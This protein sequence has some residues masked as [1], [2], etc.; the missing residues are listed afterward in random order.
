MY[1]YTFIYTHIRKYI[2]HIHIYIFIH[3]HTQIHTDTHKYTNTSV[4]LCIYMHKRLCYSSL[5]LIRGKVEPQY[6][7]YHNSDYK[8]DHKRRHHRK[9]RC[10]SPDVKIDKLHSQIKINTIAIIKVHM[11]IL[12]SNLNHQSPMCSHN[13][14]ESLGS[15]DWTFIGWYD[16]ALINFLM[17]SN[18][19]CWHDIIVDANEL[20]ILSA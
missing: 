19:K 8:F 14:R 1:K 18:S 13:Q 17:R 6:S 11:S 7:F 12:S 16:Q 5:E 15:A 4:L 9:W 10:W 3:K 2:K 20:L